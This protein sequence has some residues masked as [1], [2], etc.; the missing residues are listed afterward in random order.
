MHDIKIHDVSFS[1]AGSDKLV[2]KD[3][4]VDVEGGE[5]VC[6]LGQSGCGKSTLLRLIAGL[7]DCTTGASLNRGVVFQDYGL[8]PWKTAGANITLALKKKFPDWD[9]NHLK[10]RLS[11]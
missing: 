1:Y 11:Y 10:E 4:N 5:F 3:I 7:E 6:I 8:F 9:K 2:L